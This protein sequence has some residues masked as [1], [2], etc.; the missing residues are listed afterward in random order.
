VLAPEGEFFKY[1]K[2]PGRAAARA[3]SR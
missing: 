3:P 2:D 1:L